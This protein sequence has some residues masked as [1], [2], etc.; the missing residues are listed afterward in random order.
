MIKFWTKSITRLLVT[1]MQLLNPDPFRGSR[2]I[3]ESRLQQLL[4]WPPPSPPRCARIFVLALE[5]EI[6]HQ[7][8]QADRRKNHITVVVVDDGSWSIL[9]HDDDCAFSRK[10]S[11]PVLK[12]HGMEED[13]SYYDTRRTCQRGT[14][15]D[16]D[17]WHPITASLHA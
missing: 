1:I 7:S 15:N 13:C 2:Q 9:F 11:W 3:P 10:S 17:E 12:Y 5:Q 6:N 8:A 16:H 4:Y 14:T